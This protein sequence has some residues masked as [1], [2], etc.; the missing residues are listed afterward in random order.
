[1]TPTK[2]P[3]IPAVAGMLLTVMPVLTS[4]FIT[5]EVITRETV[6]AAWTGPEW[7]I[8]TLVC[9]VTSTFALT[10][11]TFLALVFG[12]FLGWPALLPVFFLNMAA[13][14]LVNLLVRFLNQPQ[15]LT[16][17]EN[18]K[19]A[20]QVLA[21]IH[22]RE[23]WFIFFAKLSPVLPFALTN[24]VFALS[25]ARLRNILLGGFMG[26]IPRTI[27][28]VGAGLQAQE[29][30]QLLEHPNQASGMQLATI[31]LFVASIIG[32]WLVLGRYKPGKVPHA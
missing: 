12:Y 20:R 31:G 3:V 30:R 24:L 2:K 26:M 8:A 10:P 22:Q 21:R 16:Y 7:L 6:F 17:L 14:A 19:N 13:I 9:C 32:F 25:G 18:N 4:S 28:A 29:L 15:L 23:L 5:Y 27:L 11:P 1:M